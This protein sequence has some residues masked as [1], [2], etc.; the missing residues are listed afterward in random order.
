MGQKFMFPSLV[1]CTAAE[2]SPYT[3]SLWWHCSSCS[4]SS[5]GYFR[6]KSHSV[7]ERICYS[8]KQGYSMWIHFGALTSGFPQVCC[9]LMKEGS[10]APSPSF[11]FCWAKV[12]STSCLRPWVDGRTVIRRS[13]SRTCRALHIRPCPGDQEEKGCPVLLLRGQMP[14]DCSRK[15]PH[16]SGSRSLSNWDGSDEWLHRILVHLAM[17]ST[18]QLYWHFH[19]PQSLDDTK[20]AKLWFHVFPQAL[21]CSDSFRID[22]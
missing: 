2:S 22:R 15:C 1:W 14:A 3:R 8:S 6:S 5:S 13:R 9:Q 11:W 21:W 20:S 16:S 18:C 4:C 19:I 17:R 12:N 7:L 10:R